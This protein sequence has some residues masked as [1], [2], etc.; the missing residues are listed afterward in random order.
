MNLTN[1]TLNT[2]I[3]TKTL[4]FLR[5]LK[6]NVHMLLLL[7]VGIIHAAVM[8]I[9]VTVASVTPLRVQ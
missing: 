3:K 9:A 7:R 6:L 2:H 1:L 5:F 4:V 8:F